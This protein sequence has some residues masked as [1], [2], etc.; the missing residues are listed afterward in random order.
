QFSIINMNGRMYDPVLGR[1]MSPDPYLMG[2]TQGYNRY[3]Y[4]LNNPLKYTDPTGNF[5]FAYPTLG[6]SLNGGSSIGLTVGVG[7]PAGFGV[8][9]N[10]NYSVRQDNFTASVGAYAG[11]FSASVSWSN[12]TGWGAYAGIGIGYGGIGSTLGVGVGWSE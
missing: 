8:F 9:A 3:T 11:V 7:F 2:G 5:I 10:V 12:R 1:M 6:Y 4:C